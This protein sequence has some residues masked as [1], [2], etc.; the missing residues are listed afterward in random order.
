MQVDEENG[1]PAKTR[2]RMIDRAGNRAA[3][4]EL[5][6]LTGRTHQLRAHM[7]A[8]GHPIVGDAKYG[9]A[10][11]FLTGGV[12]RKLHLHARR[13]R[14]DGPDGET[15]DGSAELPDHFAESLKMLG[16]DP[17]A[18]D[19]LPLDTSDYKTDPEV[20]ARRV[21]AAA[22]TGARAQGRAARPRR[23]QRGKPRKPAGKPPAK[24][25]ARHRQTGRQAGRQ[26]GAQTD[27]K[28]ARQTMSKLAIFDCDGTLV[29]SGGTIHRA[30]RSTFDSHGLDCPPRVVTKKVIGLSLDEAFARWCPTATIRRCRAP[31]RTP[32]SRCA[33]RAWSRSRCSTASS[34]RSTRSERRAGCLAWRPA[35]ATRGLDHCL[36]AHGIADRFVT[37]QTA[38]HHPSK[39]HPSMVLAA[40]AEAG[41][42]ADAD[43]VHRRYGVGHGRRRGPPAAGRSAPAG[44]IMTK[45][46]CATPGRMTWRS[47]RPN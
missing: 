45:P 40:I 35:R 12:S 30:L 3:W 46:N 37:L 25:A 8:I 17:L 39:P 2:Y 6:P 42:S 20:K 11:A 19:A 34:P 41:S 38:D 1:L 28:A 47:I 27:R 13:L 22:K 29:D 44:A 14:I 32:F 7:A 23:A 33:A 15:I 10:E 4:V 31:T 16:F 24:P 26:A 21:A 36:A 18:G 43:R 5:Q 9:G